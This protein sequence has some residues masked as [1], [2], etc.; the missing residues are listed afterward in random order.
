MA[1]VGWGPDSLLTGNETHIVAGKTK[2][3]SVGLHR[4]Q[5]NT[6][7]FLSALPVHDHIERPPRLIGVSK[8]FG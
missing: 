1:G 2:F 6:N 3:L 8:S 7:A 4:H 5:S